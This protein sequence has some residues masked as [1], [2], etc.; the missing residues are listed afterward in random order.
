MAD[1]RLASIVRHVYKLAALQQTSDAS[2]AS[3]LKQ[4]IRQRDESAFA[5]FVRRHGPLVWRVCRR[6]LRHSQDAEEVYQATFLVLAR[7]AAR[8]R[9]PAALASFLY[10]V[11]YLIARKAQ[12]DH[13]RRQSRPAEPIA[14]PVGDPASEA[15]WREIEQ[16]HIEEVHALPEKYRTPVLLCY[17][18]GL[19]NEEAS[20][21]LGWPTGTVKTRLLKA[22]Q[23]LH[24]RL[25]PYPKSPESII[26]PVFFLC[27]RTFRGNFRGNAP[28]TVPAGPLL[29][30]GLSGLLGYDPDVVAEE[31]LQGADGPTEDGQEKQGW[32]DSGSGALLTFQMHT[33]DFRF[34]RRCS[35]RLTPVW[36]GSRRQACSRPES[37][38][39][40]RNPAQAPRPLRM[41]CRP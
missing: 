33:G 35:C 19:T 40:H 13:F 10:G 25:I 1:P 4:Y 20:R 23:F 18:E 38:T 27:R 41:Q 28:A 11:A 39:F 12:A 36:L 3:L 15:A 16:I 29:P 21:R 32:R 30:G 34:S 14:E 24:G 26:F 17:W 6:L 5:A 22:R 9:K 2:D 8:I 37:S 31:L 7:R